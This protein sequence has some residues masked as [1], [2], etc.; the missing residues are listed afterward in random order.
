VATVNAVERQE[1]LRR[2]QRRGAIFA[3]VGIV[4]ALVGLLAGSRGLFAAG[5][6]FAVLQGVL[7]VLTGRGARR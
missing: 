3:A 6:A 7:V 2:L 4:V 1:R 5:A